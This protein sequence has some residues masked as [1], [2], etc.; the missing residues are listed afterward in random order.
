MRARRNTRCPL[1]DDRDALTDILTAAL[2]AADIDPT[3]VDRAGIVDDITQHWRLVP[4][5]EPDLNIVI[6]DTEWHHVATGITVR[7]QPS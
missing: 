4:N 7:F 3:T 1:S 6:T 5:G 2:V